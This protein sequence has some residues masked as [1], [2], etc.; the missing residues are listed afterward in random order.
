VFSGILKPINTDGSSV[1]KLNSTVPVKFR[2]MNADGKPAMGATARLC[3]SRLDN[4]VP[5][6]ETE[7]VSSGWSNPGNLF[8]YDSGEDLYIFNLKTRDLSAGT[9]RLRI[10]LDDESSQYV[11]IGLR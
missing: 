1:F 7:A 10:D 3:L 6:K 8:R 9:W 5:G 11:D 2:L 4:G